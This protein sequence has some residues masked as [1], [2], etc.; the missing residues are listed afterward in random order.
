MQ[1]IHVTDVT[2]VNEGGALQCR[3]YSHGIHVPVTAVTSVTCLSPGRQVQGGAQELQR[4]VHR[5]PRSE[6]H[7]RMLLA[8]NHVFRVN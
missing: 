4:R 6:Q 7:L 2:A 5:R 8:V 3:S 1:V